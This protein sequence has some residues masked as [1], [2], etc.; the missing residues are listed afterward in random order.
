MWRA[1]A[2]PG[3][4]RGA[5]TIYQP[6]RFINIGSERACTTLPDFACV[7]GCRGGVDRRGTQDMFANIARAPVKGGCGVVRGGVPLAYEGERKKCL[8]MFAIYKRATHTFV[9][10]TTPPKERAIA[11]E[12]LGGRAHTMDESFYPG[13]TKPV[14]CWMYAHALMR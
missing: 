4:D 14:N 6:K 11:E 13:L 3:S 10:G 7:G 9:C 8:S 5:I 1:N 12:R 2:R